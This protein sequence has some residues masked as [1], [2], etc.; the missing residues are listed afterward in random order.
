MFAEAGFITLIAVPIITYRVQ[1]IMGIVYRTRKSLTKDDTDLVTAVASIMGLALSK[2][3]SLKQLDDRQRKPGTKVVPSKP[4]PAGKDEMKSPALPGSETITSKEQQQTD[5]TRDSEAYKK[6]L[7]RMRA[8][9]N[10]HRALSHE[11]PMKKPIE[12]KKWW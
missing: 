3:T 9:S 7:L 2:C 5:L 11:I 10:S 1:G 4:I 6:H 12:V 8:F